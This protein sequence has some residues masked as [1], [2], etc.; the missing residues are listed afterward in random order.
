MRNNKKQLLLVC[1]KDAQL[2]LNDLHNKEKLANRSHQGGRS[3]IEMLGVLA[4]IGALSVGGIAG[5]SKALH[6]NKINTSIEQINVI[7]GKLSTI[8]ASG[9]D[10]SGMTNRT[11][12]KLKAVLP[13]MNPS[14]DILRNPFGGDITISASSLLKNSDNSNADNQAYTITY[15]GLDGP[16]CLAIAAHDW[17]NAKNSSLIG[18]AAGLTNSITTADRDYLYLKCSGHT[19]NT[20]Y[21]V[22]VG[23]VN[24]IEKNLPL[25]ISAANE[26]CSAC[27][28]NNCSVML[29]YY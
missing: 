4:I 20:T 19:Y 23:C 12:I 26:S 2:F 16:A 6:Q 17:G 14:G 21:A 3:M 18:V 24:G 28:N 5:Y 13:E 15:S 1:L 29:K 11:A 9:G 10:Y 8:G 25:T 27:R 7:S 22:T